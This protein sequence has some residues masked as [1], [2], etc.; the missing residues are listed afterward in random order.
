M[1]N[2]SRIARTVASAAAY[3]AEGASASA[4]GIAAANAPA[5]AMPA[6]KLA[7]IDSNEGCAYWAEI[8]QCKSNPEY[9]LVTC[10]L[11]CSVCQVSAPAAAPG[12]AASDA[13]FEPGASGDTRAEEL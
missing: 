9:M 8:G 3:V 1:S 2:D 4:S 12:S 5:P 7:C 13:F 6:I 11:S 10:K